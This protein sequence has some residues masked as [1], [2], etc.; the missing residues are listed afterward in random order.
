MLGASG[1]KGTDIDTGTATQINGLS[2]PPQKAPYIIQPDPPH[3]FDNVLMQLC[4]KGSKIN[5]FPN[6]NYPAISPTPVNIQGFLDSYK[7]VPPPPGDIDD[8]IYYPTPLPQIDPNAVMKCF[9]PATLPVLSTLAKQFA[10]CDNWFSSIPGPTWPNRYFLHAATSGGVVA[11]PSS[12]C[13]FKNGTIFDKLDQNGTSWKVYHHGMYT[14]ILSIEGMLEKLLTDKFREYVKDFQNDINSPDFNASYIFIEPDQSDNGNS[15]HPIQDIRNGELLIQ[16]IYEK[17]RKSP[18]WENSALIILYDEHGG[19]YDHVQAPIAVYPGDDTSNTHI[20]NTQNEKNFKYDRLGLR[21]P[22]VVISPYTPLNTIDHTL[23]DHTSVIATL[24]KRFNLGP[25]GEKLL[26]DR[27][28][29]A[30]TFDKL[31][32]LSSPRKD[33][34]SLDNIV[35]TP[36]A[37]IVNSNVIGHTLQNFLNL[38]KTIDMKTSPDINTQN[39]ITDKVNAI[40]N[41]TDAHN[42]IMSVGEKISV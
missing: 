35:V 20:N 9:S 16:D 34:P 11:S 26:T 36:T 32:S 12:I 18:L 14:Q 2:S 13:K 3:E 10:V 24:N 7:T 21:V 33:I 23:Y 8:P 31:F 19:F 15:Q 40:T 42:Y 5:A 22:A 37:P 28:G 39:A 30:N 41:A 38:A 4:G 6:N 27:D 29:Y 1:I 25:V 17:L